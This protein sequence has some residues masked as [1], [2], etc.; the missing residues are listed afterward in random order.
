MIASTLAALLVGCTDELA[1]GPAAE[2][3]S[4]AAALTGTVVQLASDS[5]AHV[6]V[7]GDGKADVC[8][9]DSA[10]I[11]CGTSNGSAFQNVALWSDFYRDGTIEGWDAFQGYW[12][13]NNYETIAYPDINGDGKS[14]VC[15]LG[16]SGVWCGI[17]NGTG[18]QVSRRWTTRFDS[19][20]PERDWSPGA[21]SA[22]TMAFPD[23]NRDGASD[24]CLRGVSGVSCALSDHAGSF[25]GVRLW[26]TEFSN[27]GGWNRGKYGST[28]RFPDVDGDGRS[29]VCG[30]GESGI[31]CQLA[32]PGGSFGRV[33]RWS[34]EFSDRLGW[35]TSRYASLR[36]VDLNGDKRSDLC[37]RGKDGIL[38]VVSLGG[39][40]G[41]TVLASPFFNDANGWSLDMY[42]STIR[43]PDLNGDGQ[44]DVC[45]RGAAGVSCALSNG[46][47][48][49]S[50]EL[51]TPEYND[52]PA[53]WTKS[54]YYST[55]RFPDLDGDGKADVCGRGESGI[56]CGKSLS[57]AFTTPTIWTPGFADAPLPGWGRRT[58]AYSTIKY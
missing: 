16:D 10:G 58:G 40:F 29:D 42:E 25:V 26:T 15:G 3:E 21:G 24:L 48:F 49:A 4:A 51:W 14:D 32:L 22:L 28:V 7:N 46:A 38:C 9:R 27:G 34:T 5:D 41:P 19:G 17:S 39:S 1:D 54:A 56:R 23:L 33:V 44:T 50:A 20:D 2:L 6:D 43:Y 31:L 55:I 52:V 37:G 13:P 47:T 12:Q 8:G 36:Y 18:F 45:G 11:W 57:V 35:D 30:R 53:G